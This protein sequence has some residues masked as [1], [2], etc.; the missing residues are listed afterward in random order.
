VLPEAQ[1][2]V[3]EAWALIALVLVGVGMLVG[4]ALGMRPRGADDLL[5]AFWLGWVGVL[6]GLQLWHLVLP[7]D[8]RA[9]M[10]YALAGVVGLLVGGPRPWIQLVRRLPW[11]VPALVLLAA[12]AVWF[13]NRA[14]GGARYGDTGAY[15]VPTVRWLVEYPIVPGLGNLH[16]HY[17]LNQSY[18]LYVALLEWGPF[19][20]RSF[21]LA[22]SLLVLALW[23]RIALA[24]GRL[25]R[26][27]SGADPV[28]LLWALVA[29]GV[30]P[31]ALGIL[32]TSPSPDTAVFALGVMM[33]AELLALVTDASRRD[34]HLRAA[35]LFAAT[36]VTVKLSFAGLGVAGV[37]VALGLWARRERPDAGRAL[38]AVVTTGV[39]GLVAVGPWVARNVVLSGCP[40]F[41]NTLL[42][43]PVEWRVRTNVEG[44][45][46]QTVVQGGLGA[47]VAN[48]RWYLGRLVGWGWNAP[49]VLG[50]IL[51]GSGGVLVGALRR[52]VLPCALVLPALASL[53]FCLLM[54]PVPR[55]AGATVWLLAAHGLLLA[56]G[57]AVLRPGPLLRAGTV[58]VA[59]GAT[60]FG[61]RVLDGPLWLPLRDFEPVGR[62]R[63]VE[64]R[65]KTGL[66]VNRP[67]ITEACWDAP[68]PCTPFTNPALRLRRDGDMSAGF[69]LDPALQARYR[70][71]PGRAF[72]G[73]RT[74]R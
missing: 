30:L 26:V 1:L 32:Y 6:L 48:P 25:M 46:R 5:L 50:P 19:Y 65:L 10:A 60:V 47:I 28:D 12:A 8:D 53:V 11:N 59:I 34:V 68:L 7:I 72:V 41:P 73:R 38:R 42:A 31:L 49:E 15:F 40:F 3:L 71:E 35:V 29:P 74:A 56:M 61:L 17:A 24:A 13:S 37:L 66:V 18:F 4:R 58:V 57:A 43:L 44:W 52:R 51:V 39:L 54:S 67:L 16:G 27:R 9:R 36:G 20:G 21:H 69:M 22:N 62:V 23:A 2:L 70:Y 14:L 55:Y 63:W 45:L 33:S 64:R